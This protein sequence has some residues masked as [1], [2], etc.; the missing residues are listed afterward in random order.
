[1]SKTITIRVNDN[2]Y[3]L[4]KK[5]AAGDRRSI[6]NFIENATLS[7]LTNE[8]YVSDEEMSEILSNSELINNLEKGLQDIKKGKYKIVG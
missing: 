5:A 1:M 4:F 6:S 2:I 7:Y 3:E 8:T